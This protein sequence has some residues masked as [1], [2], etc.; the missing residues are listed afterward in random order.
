[1]LQSIIHTKI[2]FFLFSFFLQNPMNYTTWWLKPL[3]LLNFCN[4]KIAK[5]FV[6]SKII[7][8]NGNQRGLSLIKYAQGNGLADAKIIIM[9]EF[10]DLTKSLEIPKR[11]DFSQHSTERTIT[12]SCPSHHIFIP[13]SSISWYISSQGICMTEPRLH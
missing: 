5:K 12:P 13:F 8:G 9:L 6:R 3:T 1:M 11:E 4:L 7:H 2:K 10:I